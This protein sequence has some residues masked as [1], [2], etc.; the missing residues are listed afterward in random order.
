MQKYLCNGATCAMLY[1]NKKIAVHIH[2]SLYNPA[3]I[4]SRRVKTMYIFTSQSS[5]RVRI[6]D[7][8]KVAVSF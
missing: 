7:K 5:R 6:I 1:L 8:Q 4:Y 2:N 3:S